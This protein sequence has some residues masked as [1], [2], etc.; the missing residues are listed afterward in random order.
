MHDH[1]CRR[2][3]LII[4]ACLT[5]RAQCRYEYSVLCQ[6]CLD[7]EEDAEADEYLSRR[8]Y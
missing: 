8:G 4:E 6:E 3:G 5:T 2:C 1:E 7:D